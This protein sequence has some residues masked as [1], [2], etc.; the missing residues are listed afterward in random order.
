M[1]LSNV[2]YVISMQTY[3]LYEYV[4][5]LL[6]PHQKCYNPYIQTHMVG[7]VLWRHIKPRF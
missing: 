4:K 7:V 3:R 1:V 5:A 6:A 2:T